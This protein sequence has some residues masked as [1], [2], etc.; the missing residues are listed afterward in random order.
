VHERLTIDGHGTGCT[1]ASAIAANL[2][3]ELSL[4]DACGA[5]TDY[6]NAALR[7][8]YRPGRGDVLVLDHFRAGRSL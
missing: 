4:P 1:L 2:C 6:V 3:K 8:G 7:D 5:A